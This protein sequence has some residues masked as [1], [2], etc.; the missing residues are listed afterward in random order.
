VDDVE[1]R[2]ARGYRTRVLVQGCVALVLA[3]A[4]YAAR[5]HMSVHP[6]PHEGA[7]EISSQW[8]AVFPLAYAAG[9]FAVY[10][11]RGQL[12]TRLT[13]GGIEIRRCRRRLVPWHAIRDVETISYDRVAY[14]PVANNRTRTVSARDRGPRTVAAVQIVRSSGHRIQLPAPLVTRSQDDPDFNDKVQLIKARWQQAVTGTA[15]Y[16]GYPASY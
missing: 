6:S 9:S 4:L 12:S 15:G 2:L 1:F 7:S 5:L 8:L 3:A 14:V 13:A 11:W 10:A 16:V